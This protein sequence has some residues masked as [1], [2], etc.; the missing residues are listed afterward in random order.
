MQVMSC[1]LLCLPNRSKAYCNSTAKF[2]MKPRPTL[3]D[4]AAAARLS[5]SAVSLALRNPR[6][7]PAGTVARVQAAAKL[8]DYRPDPMLSA[9]AA[10]RR[11]LRVRRDY[12]VIALVTNWPTRNEWLVRNSAKLLWAG[13]ERRARTLGYELQHFWAR[14]PGTSTRRL[15]RILENRGI[16]GILLA[17]FERPADRLD[18]D[19]NSFS[20][21]AI[22]R[23]TH[24][25]RFHHIVPN[26]H[27]DMSLAW[28]K[29]RE[30]GYSRVG[31]VIDDGLAERVAHQ[32]EAA[33]AFEQARSPALSKNA[34]RTLI[35]SQAD[36]RDSIR[37]WLRAYQP[38]AVISRSESFFQVLRL[39]QPKPERRI[40]YV[41]LN[42]VD[43]APGVS[44]ILQQRDTMGEVAIDALNSLLLVS[45]RGLSDVSLGTHVDGA[46]QSGT[47]LPP[48]G[49]PAPAE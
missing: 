28:G 15:S 42:V 37:R 35:L 6:A 27:A 39:I 13:A 9:L 16:R 43:D 11:R 18:L 17:P 12:S 1:L 23:P 2:S 49:K 14:E 45:Q 47:T 10:H 33:H 48:R 19:W 31:L 29:I 34:V 41:S 40:G 24:Y 7:L 22:E 30:L 36:A 32:W 21:V 44:G 46:W 4:V 38:D 20:V 26:Y 5:I 25:A 3:K 8:L